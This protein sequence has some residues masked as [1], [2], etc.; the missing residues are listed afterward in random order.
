LTISKRLHPGSQLGAYRLESLLGAG[1]MGEVYRAKDVRLGRW[2]AIKVL[3][4]HISADAEARQR[5]E[6]EA[7]TIA[8]LNHPNICTLHDI[9]SE[10]GVDYLVMEYLEGDTLAELLK[11]RRL[12]MDRVVDHG[13]AIASALAAAH[14]QSIVHRDL[15]PGNIILARSGVKVLDFGLAKFLGAGAV[16]LNDEASTA[17]PTLAGTPAYMAPEQRAGKECDART[18]IYAFG[19]V[20]AE[21]AT[22]RGW[23]SAH[24]PL[25]SNLPRQ[26]AFVVERCLAT[27]PDDRWQSC[28][29]VRL[30]LECIAIAGVQHFATRPP[31]AP[32]TRLS[33]D[34]G[35]DAVPGLRTTVALSPDGKRIVFLARGADGKHRMATRLLAEAEATL[36]QG[37][38]NA[39]DPF[40]SPDGKWLGFFADHRLKRVSVQ[41][42]APLAVCE[43]PNDRGA[44]WADNDSIVVAPHI[45]GGLVRVHVDGGTPEPLTTPAEREAAHGWPQ[46][47]AGGEAVL[48][49]GGPVDAP[50]VQTLSLSTHEMKV[51]IPAGYRGRYVPS[52]HVVYAHRNTLF[53]VPFDVGSREIRGAP[54]PIVDDVEDDV[55]DRTAHFDFANDGTLVYLSRRGLTADRIIAWMDRSGQIEKLLEAPGRYGYLF[56]SPDGRKLSFVSGREVSVLDFK[57]GRPSRVSFNTLDNQWPV[58]APDSAH[59]VFSAQNANGIGRSLW[60]LRADGSEEPQILL[61]SADEL[62]PSS[63][64][65]D[66]AHVAIHRRSPET[67]YDIFMLPLDCSDPERPEAGELEVFLRTPV[68]EWGAV[69]SPDGRWVAYYSEESGTGEIY[70]R[71]FRGR[72]G[73]WLVSS[74]GIAGTLA[75]W[76]SG[77]R[78]LY[79]L[80]TDRHIME[81][82]Y[83]EEGNS[84][85]ADEPRRWSE[86][87]LP[88]AAFNV[89]SDATRAIIAAPAEALDARHTLH[90]TFVLNLF[91]ELHRRAPAVVYDGAGSLGYLAMS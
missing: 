50:N 68:I 13:M 61:E 70:V 40:F 64:S 74:G 15:K 81:V 5:F 29:D 11:T 9:G 14:K 43:A 75:H 19:L 18:D 86:A 25:P 36:L 4:P 71:P 63:V 1:G 59:L 46:V 31:E 67:L 38:E 62:H 66:G 45:F 78:S 69:F 28:I 85:I 35:R 42:G 77:G 76:P 47:I 83:T 44:S 34:L 12:R 82:T 7:R 84:F 30:A 21:M 6:R 79:Y 89:S 41:G 22:G 91:D 8:N 87:T 54:V 27:D 90:V 3:L 48:F 56:P 53:A 26:F 2:V 17:Q 72:G 65:P 24:E 20:L 57:R 33:V 51:V 32:L 49:T 60:W 39:Q 23:M 88:F 55:S 37:T 80:S 73:P 10:G 16:V 58:W 52:G